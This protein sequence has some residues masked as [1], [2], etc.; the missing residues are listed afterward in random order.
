MVAGAGSEER[1]PWPYAGLQPCAGV[2]P[3]PP[4]GRSNSAVSH[5]PH[6]LHC[7]I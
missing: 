4:Y 5:S 2:H 7:A 3:L 6:V 1:W